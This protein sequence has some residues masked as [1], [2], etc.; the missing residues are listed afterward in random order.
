[1]SYAHDAERFRVEQQAKADAALVGRRIE[2]VVVNNAESDRINDVELTLD[3]G[4]TV[5]FSY[6]AAYADD[7]SM[8][9]EVDGPTQHE[10][11]QDPPDA[12]Q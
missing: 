1:M 7:A 9:I 5:Q 2:K 3:N 4:A 12:V 10:T 8:E 6:W 11:S